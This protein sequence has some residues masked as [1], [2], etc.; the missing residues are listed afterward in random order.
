MKSKPMLFCRVTYRENICNNRCNE[1]KTLSVLK[2][3]T[4][5]VKKING[6]CQLFLYMHISLNIIW[7]T[8]PTGLQHKDNYLMVI[9]L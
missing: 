1:Y 9:T 6:L 8:A 5:L 3:S 4:V 2:V 7:Y